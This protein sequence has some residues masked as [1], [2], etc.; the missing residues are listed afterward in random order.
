MSDILAKSRASKRLQK[1]KIEAARTGKDWRQ[2]R[3]VI[4]GGRDFVSGSNTDTYGKEIP[5]Y[6]TFSEESIPCYSV[7]FAD[8]AYKGINHRG[9]FA[10]DEQVQGTVR[11]IVCRIDGRK[12]LVGYYWSDNGEYVIRADEVYDNLEDAAQ[13]ADSFA[14]DYAEICR[15]DNAKFQAARLLEDEIEEKKTRLQECIALRNH[16]KMNHIRA[17]I[18]D[19][20]E[21]IRNARETLRTDYANYI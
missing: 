8:K 12:W 7:E 11:G 4:T 2:C 19:L 5:V 21:S 13:A 9:W 18:P 10:D 3:S 15:E 16:P 6:F 14:E 20:I 17:E 1:Y